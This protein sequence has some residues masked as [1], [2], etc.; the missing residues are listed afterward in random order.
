MTDIALQHSV[1]GG[2]A[3]GST[4]GMVVTNGSAAYADIIDTGGAIALMPNRFSPDFMP[5]TRLDTIVAE[6][7]PPP[8]PER[9]SAHGNAEHRARHSVQRTG[10]TAYELAGHARGNQAGRDLLDLDRPAPTGGAT[11]PRS[12]PCGSMAHC[13]SPPVAR[14][15]VDYSGRTPTIKQSGQSSRTRRISKAGPNTLRWAAVEAAQHAWRPTSPWNRLYTDTK[16]RDG[17]ANPAKAA[18]A[19][20]VLIGAWHVLARQRPFKPSC[21]A[22]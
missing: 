15:L 18:V 1:S 11:S 10:S 6:T 17:K 20:K 3:T 14:H 2:L 12:S 7:Y 19:P 16:T 13:T 8:H 4:F 21:A 5:I 9:R 22:A